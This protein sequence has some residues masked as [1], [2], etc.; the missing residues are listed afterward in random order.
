[1]PMLQIC[2]TIVHMLPDIIY[3][4]DDNGCF[5]YVNN[6]VR[7]LGYEPADLI[8]KHFSKL[9]HPEDLDSVRRD[10]VIKK[11]SGK[12]YPA[13]RQPKLFDER[14]TGK[15][16]T[17]DLQVRLIP[18]SYNMVSDR[19]AEVTASCRVIAVG[20][21]HARAGAGGREFTGT[22]GI[23]RDVLNVKKSED[24]LV[25]CIDYYQSLVELSNDIFFVIATDGTIMFSSPS[26]R[27]ILGYGAGELSGENIMD[28]LPDADFKNVIRAYWGSNR[29]N[30]LFCVQCRIRH[31]D[32]SWRTFDIKGRPVH[33][34]HGRTM[35]L[36]IV[37]HDLTGRFKTEEEL[38]KAHSELELRV[39]DRTAELAS[40]NERLRI[41]IK[42]RNRQDSIIIDSEKKYRNLV[43]S[44]DDIVLTMD[45]EGGILFVNQALQRITGHDPRDVIGCSLMDL[46]HQDDINSCIASLHEVRENEPVNNKILIG[47]VYAHNEFRMMKKD[48]SVIWVELRCHPVRDAGGCIIAFRGIGHDITRR[49]RTEEEMI[50]ESKIESLGILAAGIAHDFN[51]L[52][53]A[54][55]GNISLAKIT[56]RQEDPN[57]TILSDAENASAMA[58]NLTQ[59]LM[60]FSRGGS[61]IRKNTSIRTL[62]VDTAYFVLRGSPV[63]IVF[64]IE[65]SLW[66][67]VVDR[68]QIGQVMNNIILNAR[69]SMPEGGTIRVA[70]EN[71]VLGGDTD[72]PLKGGRYIKI[73][74][75]DQGSG[76]PDDIL[77]R[78]FD[79]Y[80]STKETGSGL[81]LAISYS[82]V[83]KHEGLIFVESVRGEGTTFFIYLP[84]S[85]IQEGEQPGM[86]PRQ[87]IP[88]RK[89]K[90]LL[91][92]DES[93]ILDLGGRLLGHLGYEVVAASNSAEAVDLFRKAGK[94][95]K[96]FD[97]VIL[98]LIIPGGAGA[99]RAIA[100]LR[101]IDPG[102]RAIVTSGYAD[103]PVMVDYGKHGFSGVLVK[104][105][106]LED[107]EQE[108]ARVLSL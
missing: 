16:I 104:P 8:S 37:A 20:S 6:S 88:K 49:K 19:G 36:T 5:T 4:L 1:M 77:P 98:D 95:G 65:Y 102:I 68:G 85:V 61:P 92:D 29:E 63:R 93:I 90:I 27:R 84:A 66:D 47:E 17:R 23:I 75:T 22:L 56:I 15:R 74:I 82:I 87:V 72:L 101:E 80:F 10:A 76:I 71:C 51:N 70:A 31:R 53:T 105:F 59:Q 48:G 41:E 67:A 2:E 21:Y 3:K 52:L 12:T 79:P 54:I 103:D 14:R 26:L 50:R 13:D 32:G 81:G 55:M 46:I 62:I 60:A 25:R 44:I 89:G 69:Q 40:A 24:T 58:K 33:D 30:P 108:L 73:A 107:F 57:F 34:G 43:N 99:D 100:A 11:T 38:R 45:P 28:Y 35:Y 42:N 64:N 78:I 7:N 96:P 9:I 97:A 91:M 94:A 18:K 83:K 106:S 86:T 39:A